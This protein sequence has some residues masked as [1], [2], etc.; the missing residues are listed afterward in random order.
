M[1]RSEFLKLMGTGTVSAV[2]GGIPVISQASNKSD[3]KIKGFKKLTF[4]L[5]SQEAKVD[6]PVTAIVIGAGSRGSTYAAYARQYP[7][8][9]TIL[10]VSDIN[11]ERKKR[12]AIKHEIVEDHQFGD[13][14][15]VFK[16]PKFADAV[17]ISTPDNL[18]YEPC[19]KAL[20]MGYDVLLEKPV[21]QS[22]AECKNILKQAK[23]YGRIVG[24][25][26]VLRYAPYFIALKNVIDEGAIGDIVSI[27]H[28]EAIR[29]HH[30]LT[31]MLGE[32]GMIQSK[33][34]R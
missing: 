32:T 13:W 12:M 20:S 19:M 28:F 9:F 1:K 16:M 14:S 30:M 2:F 34:L 4:G 25:C 31:L 23:K 8:S 7:N 18:H 10:G 15:E 27:Q 24:V 5:Q 6:K 33:L 17:I 11:E 21:A 29:H 3:D 22:V 26:H